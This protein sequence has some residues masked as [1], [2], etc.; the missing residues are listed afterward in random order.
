MAFDQTNRL[1]FDNAA[2]SFPKPDSVVEAMVRYQNTLG[3]SPGRGAYREA[4]DAAGV[5][6]ECR[7]AINELIGGASPD[8][9]VFTLNTSDALNTAIKGLLRPVSVWVTGG[10]DTGRPVH[11]IVTAMEHNSVLRPVNALAEAFPGMLEVTR[12]EADDE[13]GLIDPERIR[14][15]V[16]GR[17]KLVA[18]V[19]GSNVTGTVQ[20]IGRIGAICREMAVPLLVDAAQTA[21]H[22]PINVQQMNI[23]ML[24]APGHKGLLGPL[25]TGFLYL[26]PGME[27]LIAT[28]REGGT[29]SVSEED[30]HPHTMP[31]KYEAGSH[32]AIGIAG[33]LA[34]VRFLLDRGVDKLYEHERALVEQFIN[35]LHTYTGGPMLPG[36]RLLGP[37]G[38][39]HRVGVFSVVIDGMSPGELA[40]TLEDRFGILTRPGLHCAPHVHRTFRTDPDSAAVAGAMP[41]ATRFSVGPF[42]TVQDVKY[43]TDALSIICDERARAGTSASA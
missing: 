33:L 32:N 35:G 12:I 8:H 18:V 40:D 16:T 3:A 11:V 30:T 10:A 43:A 4:R 7:A 31:D 39:R 14:E 23:D 41:G 17:T 22:M 37:Q 42:L 36:L 24:A 1:Y 6:A 20:D 25:G 9:V 21:G 27:K 38:V 5:L 34:G 13:T 29:G 26:R 2:T 28:S 19:H 15:A